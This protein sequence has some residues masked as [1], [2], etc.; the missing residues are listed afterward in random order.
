MN[1]QIVRHVTLVYITDEAASNSVYMNIVVD[2][3][4]FNGHYYCLNL[5]FKTFKGLIKYIVV[6]ITF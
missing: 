3:Y 2:F 5:M 1:K 4:V 6:E